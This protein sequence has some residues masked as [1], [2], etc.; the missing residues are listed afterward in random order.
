MPAPDPSSDPT[1]TRPS[2]LLAGATGLVGRELLRQLLCDPEVGEVRALVRRELSAEALLG[3]PV[4]AM[5]GVGKLRIG[6]VDYERLAVHSEWFD[7]DWVASALG[8]TIRDAGSQAAFRRVDLDYPLQVMQLA[9]AQGARRAMLVSAVGARATSHVFY[10]R[11]KGELEDAVRDIGFEQV[12]V[13]RPSLLQGERSVLRPAERLGLAFGWLMP[14]PYKPVAA[15]QVAAGL[16]NSAKAG[17]PGW[18]V[19]SNTALRAM[20]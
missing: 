10:N 13:A 14:A 4:A 12:S 20:R 5:P 7:V 6:V 8:T 16:L 1:R 11:V 9:H 17:V 2:V 3:T 15:R 18:H 19:L